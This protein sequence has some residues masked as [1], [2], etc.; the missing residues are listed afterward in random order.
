MYYFV[1]IVFTLKLL[2]IPIASVDHCASLTCHNGGTCYQIP[3]G[4]W[5]DC[6]PG[7]SGDACEDGKCFVSMEIC[8]TV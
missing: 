4:V 2:V 6:L 3:A 5:C 1:W 7:S 8:H